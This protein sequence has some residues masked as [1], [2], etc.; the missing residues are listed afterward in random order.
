MN[1]RHGSPLTRQLSRSRDRGDGVADSGFR[2]VGRRPAS[3]SRLWG[4]GDEF[5][6]GTRSTEAGQWRAVWWRGEHGIRILRVRDI[7]GDR[8]VLAVTDAA[9]APD[10][11]DMRERFPELTALWDAIR[12]QFWVRAGE[13]AG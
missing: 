7:V 1:E 8:T 3:G 6:V 4:G 12:H 10:L 13:A 9:N 11:A 5:A 2:A